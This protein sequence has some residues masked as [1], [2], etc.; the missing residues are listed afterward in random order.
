MANPGLSGNFDK[1]GKT[2]VQG[3]AIVLGAYGF[4]PYLF[5]KRLFPCLFNH[6]IKEKG[7]IAGMPLLLLP[8]LKN[9]EKTNMEADDK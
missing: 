9:C 1:S 5:L 7:I 2:G 6:F 3:A 4:V 8:T